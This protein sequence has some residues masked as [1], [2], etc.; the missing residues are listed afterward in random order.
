[1]I[2]ERSKVL[3]TLNWLKDQHCN[4][5]FTMEEESNGQL[6][7]LDVLIDHQNGNLSFGVYRKPT[8][9]QRYITSDSYH[10][11]SHKNAVFHSMTHRLCNSRISNENYLREKKTIL[12][13]GRLNGYKHKKFENHQET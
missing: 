2:I 13:L 3:D 11:Q 4:I 12:D 5:K 8:S 6:P 9:T 7:F 1:V 10:P